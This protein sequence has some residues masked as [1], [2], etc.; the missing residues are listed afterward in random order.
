MR[1]TVENTQIDRQTL[2]LCVSLVEN[3]VDPAALAVRPRGVPVNR[4]GGA[5]VSFVPL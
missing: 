4:D 2:S 5:N 3:G 1:V